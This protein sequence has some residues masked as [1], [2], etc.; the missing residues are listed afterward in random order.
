M[1][2]ATFSGE[3]RRFQHE[4]QEAYE[5]CA[6][7]ICLKC[8][9]TPSSSRSSS[10]ALNENKCDNDFDLLCDSGWN[11]MEVNSES[12]KEDC[13]FDF[14]NLGG[15]FRLIFSFIVAILYGNVVG[16]FAVF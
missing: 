7:F 10:F 4:V 14:N 2:V 5:M 1:F 9:P 16:C 11:V 13:A 15:I 12:R 6:C 8:F 3:Q